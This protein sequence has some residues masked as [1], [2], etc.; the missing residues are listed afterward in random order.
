MQLLHASG[1]LTWF[2][3]R[4]ILIYFL[5]MNRTLKT[6]LLWLLMAVLPLNAVAAVM[7]MSCSALHD[8]K[9]P[10]AA[11]DTAAHHGGTHTA[12]DAAAGATDHTAHHGDGQQAAPTQDE[13]GTDATSTMGHTTCSACSAFCIGAV[14][15]PPSLMAPQS[16]NGSEI[17]LI[18]PAP[19]LAGYVP[20]GHKRPPRHH[21][22]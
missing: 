9:A 3:L 19:W 21:S 16:S 2:K 17:V 22:A 14:A 6:L 1:G 4:I 7:G 11:V 12:A 10:T 13:P 15:P 18:S 5:Q 20:D 8:G